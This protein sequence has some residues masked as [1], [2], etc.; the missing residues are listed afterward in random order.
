MRGGPS[1][2][3]VPAEVALELGDVP[4]P[5]R[6]AAP[7]QPPAEA[8][9]A[10]RRVGRDEQARLQALELVARQ[11]DVAP[12]RADDRAERERDP[13]RRRG[14]PWGGFV[15]LR[16]TIRSTPASAAAAK[17]RALFRT[18][19]SKVVPPRSKRTQ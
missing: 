1:D 4:T 17:S 11:D 9:A 3:R 6:R 5:E 19:R 12:R 18:A 7:L 16:C 14:E 15:T 10:A 13:R 8:V 2:R